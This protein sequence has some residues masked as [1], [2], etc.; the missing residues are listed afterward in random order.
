LSAVQPAAPDPE[1]G[2]PEGAVGRVIVVRHGR[3]AWNDR[4]LYQG[5]ADVPL[6]EE[7]Y[8]QAAAL[9]SELAP[10]RPDVIVTSD[11]QRA[12][13]T[14]APLAVALG[15]EPV[16]DPRTKEIDVGLWQGLTRD[17]VITR[18]P[19]EFEAW[20]A[21]QEVTRGGTETRTSSSGRTAEAI[22]E[23]VVAAGPDQLVLIVAHGFVLRL[24]VERLAVAGVLDIPTPVPGF[25]NAGWLDL[26]VDPFPG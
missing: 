1:A 16:V 7:G 10:L 14:A 20:M 4:G 24:A 5:H 25:A 15:L 19:E 6:D 18:Y 8:R 12:Q 13:Q 2:W 11:L 3:T 9:V 21:G 17:E 22:L 23:H 26:Q